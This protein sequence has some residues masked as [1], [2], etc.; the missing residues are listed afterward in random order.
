MRRENTLGLFRFTSLVLRMSSP[1]QITSIAF[2]TTLT[3]GMEKVSNLI[4]I[5]HST[6]HGRVDGSR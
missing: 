4:L 2:I 6:L 3:I 1:S 5:D